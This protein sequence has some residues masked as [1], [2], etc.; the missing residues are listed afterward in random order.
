LSETIAYLGY[1]LRCVEPGC[2][3][4]VVIGDWIRKSLHAQG[5]NA[6][7]KHYLGMHPSLS[8]RQRSEGYARALTAAGI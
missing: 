2:Q 7:V 4:S 5:L 1:R 8:D 3:W 6:L